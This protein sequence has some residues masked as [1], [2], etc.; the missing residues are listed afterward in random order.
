M[1]WFGV[2]GTPVIFISVGVPVVASINKPTGQ[3]IITELKIEID[4]LRR[5]CAPFLNNEFPTLLVV[6]RG[7]IIVILLY[8]AFVCGCTA[9]CPDGMITAIP[10]ASLSL[11]HPFDPET[12]AT[13][14]SLWQIAN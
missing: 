8:T 11:S 5:I 9:V 4:E 14:L 12:S 6:A 13:L 1:L 7:P 10:F 2:A 3:P